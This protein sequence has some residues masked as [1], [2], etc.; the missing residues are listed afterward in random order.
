MQ[1]EWRGNIFHIQGTNRSNGFVVL[2][3]SKIMHEEMEI[4]KK[5][6]R[7]LIIKLKISNVVYT[8][9]NCYAPNTTTDKVN[10]LHQLQDKIQEIEADSLWVAGDFNVAL[11][12]TDN[13][14]GLPH[15]ER[16]VTTLKEMLANVDIHDV[17][18]TSHPDKK[19][20]AWSK[21]T[22]FTARRIDHI[23]CDTISLT[24]ITNTSIEGFSHSDHKL[25]QVKIN[26]NSFRRGPGY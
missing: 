4:V 10:F 17:W 19:E 2:T 8:F 14:A 15:H 21:P 6:D 11:E 25:A 16:E 18:R 13:I 22:P 12:Q 24:K 3:S 23:F 5:T 26:M 9:V 7:I 1:K 20:Y